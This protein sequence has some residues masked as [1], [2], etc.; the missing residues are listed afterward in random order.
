MF[1]EP[2]F[3]RLRSCHHLGSCPISAEATR[4]VPSVAAR[5]AI[6]PEVVAHNKPSEAFHDRSAST[7]VP[8]ATC[9]LREKFA[10]RVHPLVPPDYSASIYLHA[11][12]RPYRR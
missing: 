6:A 1:Y 11:A 2:A 3:L 5:G 10:R 12:P 4:Q 7:D 8:P 9:V